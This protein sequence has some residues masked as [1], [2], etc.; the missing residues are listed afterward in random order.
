MPFFDKGYISFTKEGKIMISASI[1][2]EALQ[3][4]GISYDMR[5][6]W[7]EKEHLEFLEYHYKYVWKNLPRQ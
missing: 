3:R 1:N 6:R 4:L 5:L 7:I 2:A